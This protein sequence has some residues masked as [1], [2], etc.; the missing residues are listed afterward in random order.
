MGDYCMNNS[1][2]NWIEKAE[3]D[4]LNVENNLHS[5]KIPTDTVCYHCQQFAEKY[6]KAFLTYHNKDIDKVHNLLFLLQK[7]ISIDEDFNSIRDIVAVLNLYGPSIRYPDFIENPS[8]DDAKEAYS[9]SIIVKKFIL[10]K[11]K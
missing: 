8:I 11:F 2:L 6:L 1:Y 7:C 4:L 5:K 3:N 10:S 9:Y